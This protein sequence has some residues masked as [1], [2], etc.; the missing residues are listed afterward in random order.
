MNKQRRKEL[1][2]IIED[3]DSLKERVDELYSEEEEY[4]EN[5]PENMHCGDK[6][7]ASEE[8][9]ESMQSCIESLDEA[10][11]YLQEAKG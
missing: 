1:D 3:I 7:Y 9:I 11:S 8:A 2:R 10:V 5:M 4:K 6:Y